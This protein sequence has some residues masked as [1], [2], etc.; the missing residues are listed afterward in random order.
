MRAKTLILLFVA[1][2]CGMIAAVAVSKAVMDKKPGEAAEPM[3]EIFVAAKKLSVTAEIT[4]DMVRLEKWPNKRLPEEAL[5]DL[6]Q[7]EGWYPKME[8]FPGEP[9]IQSKITE[10]L[11]NI[12]ATIPDGYRLFDIPCSKS[13]MKPGDHVDVVGTFGGRSNGR[14]AGP[15]QTQTV[16]RKVKIHAINGSSI[17]ESDAEDK[18]KPSKNL[19]FQLLVK[20]TQI[21]ALSL[22][23]TMGTLDLIICPVG[24]DNQDFEDTGDAFLSWIEDQA[25]DGEDEVTEEPTLTAFQPAP[26]ISPADA[27]E[28]EQHE[29]QII[30]PEGVTT[31]VWTKDNEIP[32]Q[33][34]DT[35]EPERDQGQG[36]GYAYGPSGIN[37]SNY[38]GYQPTYP[39]SVTPPSAS[40]SPEAPEEAPSAIN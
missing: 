31:Y 30:T 38:G 5:T 32:K 22:A 11:D 20:Q 34:V 6:E 17:R 21:E 19:V 25:A 33:K 23:N 8:I 39:T 37:Y 14:N 29:M 9:I 13:Y 26:V 24:E 36:P 35:P 4:P 16:M 12:S 3:T 15:P 28:P 40:E 7:F 27:Q 2:G 18:P 10:D 1:L